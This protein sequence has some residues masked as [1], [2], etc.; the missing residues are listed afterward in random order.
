MQRL[1]N[2]IKNIIIGYLP[3]NEWDN[4]EQYLNIKIERSTKRRKLHQLQQHT[5]KYFT[6]SA[7]LKAVQQNGDALKYVHN[8]TPEICMAAVQQN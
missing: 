1:P 3:I 4:V 5:Y 8:Q 6:D 7:A 2:D